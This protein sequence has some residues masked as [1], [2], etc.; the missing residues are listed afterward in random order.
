MK[1][2]INL[3]FHQGG[4]GEANSSSTPGSEEQQHSVER[5]TEQRQEEGQEAQQPASP[6]AAKDETAE[7][8]K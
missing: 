7:E 8:I 2:L 1:K 4:P 6:E 3:Q 5:G